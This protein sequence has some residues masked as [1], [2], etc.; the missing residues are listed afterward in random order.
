MAVVARARRLPVDTGQ[1]AA[2]LPVA[3]SAAIMSAAEPAA[4]R[5]F[6]IRC[7]RHLRDNGY[8]AIRSPASRTA[9]D[10]VAIKP[11]QTLFIQCKVGGRLDPGPWNE[12]I[13]L[14]RQYGAVPVL[15]D[16]T[17]IRY[18]WPPATIMWWELLTR[19][20]FP[21]PPVVTRRQLVID[22]LA[23]IGAMRP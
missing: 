7:L 14:A 2:R 15:A 18:G 1:L 4:G 23:Q 11:G 9:I 6:E 12:L 16:R 10:L 5:R 13:D 17:G 21:P 22:E 20:P 19:K 8:W 3:S